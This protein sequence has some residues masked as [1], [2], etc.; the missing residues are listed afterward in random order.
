[1]NAINQ[2][3]DAKEARSV[4]YNDIIRSVIQNYE[5]LPKKNSPEV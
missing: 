2:A 1:L 5:E 3:R 4:V